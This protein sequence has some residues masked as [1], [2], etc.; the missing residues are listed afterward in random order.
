MTSFLGSDLNSKMKKNLSLFF[1]PFLV[2]FF[3]PARTREREESI[4]VCE[5][6]GEGYAKF[7]EE[8]GDEGDDGGLSQWG[9]LFL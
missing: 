8:Q 5:C 6:F 1:L 4:E 2:F 3:A 9:C 7:G